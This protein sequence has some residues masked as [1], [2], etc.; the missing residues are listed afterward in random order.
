MKSIVSFDR[1]YYYSLLFYKYE[2]LICTKIYIY[3]N[4]KKYF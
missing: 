4:I 3:N 1:I 2:Q